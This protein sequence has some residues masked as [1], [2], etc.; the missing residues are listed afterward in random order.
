MI[1]KLAGNPLLLEY[2][3]TPDAQEL[4]LLT[5]IL[6]MIYINDELLDHGMVSLMTYVVLI[7]A[8]DLLHEQLGVL[9]LHKGEH[10]PVF[11]DWDKMLNNW[12]RQGYDNH[13]TYTSN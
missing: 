8:A 10:H 6:D 1:N 7:V 2:V 4:T 9:G 5:T 12:I 3:E 13:C 11:G